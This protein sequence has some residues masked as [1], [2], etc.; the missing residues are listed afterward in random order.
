MSF[1]IPALKVC[2]HSVLLLAEPMTEKLVALIK[3]VN[4]PS[5]VA[6]LNSTLVTMRKSIKLNSPVAKDLDI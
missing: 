6:G 4:V 1:C 5:A 2:A 3:S